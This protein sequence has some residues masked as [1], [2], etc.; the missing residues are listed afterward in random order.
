MLAVSSSSLFLCFAFFVSLITVSLTQ[1]MEHRGKKICVLLIPLALFGLNYVYH[2]Y[3][4][5]LLPACAVVVLYALCLAFDSV[6][7]ESMRSKFL[8]VL[9]WIMKLLPLGVVAAALILWVKGD[10]NFFMFLKIIH[11]KI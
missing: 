5:V 4:I 9:K 11:L 1:E 2:R 3:G 10:S 6:F 8:A 7:T